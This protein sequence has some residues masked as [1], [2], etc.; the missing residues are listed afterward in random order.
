VSQRL[1]GSGADLPSTG[2]FGTRALLGCGVLAGPLFVLVTAVGVLSR[3]GF[4]LRRNGISQL[5]LGD[6]GWVQV[7][8]FLVAGL[9]SLAFAVGVRRSLGR[10]L[11]GT[12]G[13]R[14]IGGYAA[15][16]IVTGLFLVD[17]GVGFPPGAEAGLPEL[18]W[19]G[20][21]HAVA[22]PAS[23]LCLV[24]VCGVFAVRYAVLRRRGWVVYCLLTAVLSLALV[25]W[26]GG[27]GSV[28]SALAV[29]VT[30]VWLTV[31]AAQLLADRPTGG[32]PALA[33]G[34]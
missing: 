21:V 30:S 18:S 20:A 9:L 28:R 19:H 1:V 16:L 26:P 11:G 32:N 34:Q 10:G 31:V 2:S 22:P 25:F 7:V 8:N 23:F 12:W 29:L 4:D 6:R 3:T 14:L 27:G 24:G 5:S 33:R 13:P 15:G 17:P